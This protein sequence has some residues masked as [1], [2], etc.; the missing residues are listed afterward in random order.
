[1]NGGES[2]DPNHEF[3]Q[4]ETPVRLNASAQ[5]P[6]PFFEHLID[7]FRRNALYFLIAG[8]VLLIVQD[9]FG[10]HGVMAM[11]RSQVEAGQI[12]AELNKLDEQNKQ[13]KDEAEHLRSDPSA[14]ER[15]ARA[16]GLKRPGEVVFRVA[17]A[18]DATHEALPLR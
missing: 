17:T 14:V 8:L 6:Q 11:R 7:F 9:I 3:S 4:G 15:A 5:P 2:M 12:R 1:M 10:T 13:L 16:N 18:S